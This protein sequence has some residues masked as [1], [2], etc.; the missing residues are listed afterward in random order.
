[1][2]AMRLP[3]TM[4]LTAESFGFHGQVHEADGGGAVHG[5][6]HLLHAGGLP[7]TVGDQFLYGDAL[8]VCAVDHLVVD[9]GEVLDEGHVVAQVL[10]ETAQRVEYDE[11]PGVADVEIVVHRGA[12]GIDAHLAF[13]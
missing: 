4:D 9:V 10:H 5:F 12:A 8:A 1:M 3:L 13:M 11:G 7:F 2:S 6:G